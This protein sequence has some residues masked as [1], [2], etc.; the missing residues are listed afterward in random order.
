MGVGKTTV[1]RLVAD[2][3]GRPLRDSDSDLSTIHHNARQM[4]ANQGVDVLHRI[5]ADLLLDALAV[6]QPLVIAAAGSVVD[7]ERALEALEQ[8]GPTVVWLTAPTATLVARVTEGNHRRDLGPDPAAAV[9]ELA[10]RRDPLYRR[11]ADATVDVSEQSPEDTA[12]AVLAAIGDSQAGAG[13]DAGN[14]G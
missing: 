4:A 6:D 2:R 13:F 12:A 1:G 11:I 7:D 9:A 10:G 5:E 8:P 3:L 14:P